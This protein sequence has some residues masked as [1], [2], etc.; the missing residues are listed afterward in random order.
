MSKSI[1]NAVY[2]QAFIEDDENEDNYF[3]FVEGLIDIFRFSMKQIAIFFLY[4]YSMYLSC[5]FWFVFKDQTT[6]KDVILIYRP[7]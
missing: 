4:Y 6:I 3:L 5:G 2:C 7:F 1:G